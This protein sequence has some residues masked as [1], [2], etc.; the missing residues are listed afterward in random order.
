[1]AIVGRR[2]LCVV[3]LCSFQARSLASSAAALSEH[4]LESF[5]EAPAQS[6]AFPFTTHVA[7]EIRSRV[8]FSHPRRSGY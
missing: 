1:M 8:T 7:D 5:F 2:Q 4:G 3:E 6:F